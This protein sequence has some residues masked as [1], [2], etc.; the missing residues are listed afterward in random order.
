MRGHGTHIAG[1]ISAKINN[2]YG[3]RGM[4]AIPTYVTRGLDDTGNAR[5]SDIMESIDQCVIA[6][7][8]VISLSL[9]GTSMSNSFK[10]EIDTLYARNV[11]I[12]AAAGN[13]GKYSESYPAS[14][15]NVVSVGAVDEGE[16]L[17]SNSNY[18]PWLELTGK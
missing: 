1:T 5:E 6:G 11:M 2:N 9:A 18:G 10:K 14:Y 8:R 7:S 12:V 4:G 13:Q 3:V 15:Y 17:W 16:N